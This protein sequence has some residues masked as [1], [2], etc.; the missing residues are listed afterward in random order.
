MKTFANIIAVALII[1]GLLLIFGA[2]GQDDV[3]DRTGEYL[4]VIVTIKKVGAGMALLL[5]GMFIKGRSK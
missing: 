2:A 3:L 1:G 5:V 4:P